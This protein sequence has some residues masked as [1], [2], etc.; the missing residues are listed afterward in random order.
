MSR[1]EDGGIFL[2]ET[3]CLLANACE[4]LVHDVLG[5]IHE[6]CKSKEDPNGMFR[7]CV[8]MLTQQCTEEDYESMRPLLRCDP[9]VIDDSFA[10]YARLSN[11]DPTRSRRIQIRITNPPIVLFLKKLL[12]HATSDPFLLSFDNGFFSPQNGKQRTH[13]IKSAIRNSFSDCA[14]DY[15]HIMEDPPPCPVPLSSSPSPSP[16]PPPP[17]IDPSDSASNI[18]SEKSGSSSATSSRAS[19]SKASSAKSSAKKSM[20]TSVKT[21]DG[22]SRQKEVSSQGEEKEG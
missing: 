11:R 14:S 4:T 6:R 3:P 18:G 16:S 7:E 21:V 15:V 2:E 8:Q 12:K 10:L 20:I 17:P 22:E 1:Y 9:K 19:G 13:S 5:S